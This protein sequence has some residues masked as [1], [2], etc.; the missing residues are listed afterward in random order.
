M[1]TGI[2]R[3]HGT[4]LT[5]VKGEDGRHSL[6]LEIPKEISTLALGDSLAVN[7]VC[8]TV[9]SKKESA[10][11]FDIME[12]TAEK[13]TLGTLIVG[14]QV[15]LE[16]SL[17][18]GDSV[19]GHFVFGHVDCVGTIVALKNEPQQSHMSIIFSNQLQ[20]FIVPKGSIAIDGVSLTIV[21]VNTEQHTFSVQL[22]AHTWAVTHFK[23]KRV[24]DTVN[25]EIDMLARY[26]RAHI[27]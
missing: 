1:F 14:Q 18:V 25:L 15:H 8:L 17:R 5:H 4:V 13:T 23:D 2:I 3:N 27:T 7:G 10:C 22:V 24:G 19:D 6:V 12:E 9:A 11:T 16:P 26:A 20:Q 21:S